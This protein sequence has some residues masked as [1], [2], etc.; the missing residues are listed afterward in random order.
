MFFKK[1][2]FL[3]LSSFRWLNQ[4]KNKDFSKIS[5]KFLKK[6]MLWTGAILLA[7]FAFVSFEIYFPLNP[8]SHE[9]ITYTVQKGWSDTQIANDLQK[10]RIIRSSFFFK[11]YLITS[12]QHSSL[13]AGKYNLSSRMSAYQIAKAM[14]HG[15][16]ISETLVIPEGWD[17]EDIG[18]Y[19][20]SKQI[21]KQDDFVKA[22]SK[23]YS[24]EFDFLKD[25]PKDIGLEGFLFPDT[26][27]VSGAEGCDGIVLIMISN[28]DKK[29]TPEIREQIASQKKTIFDI[30]TMASMLEKEVK[31][32]T[33]K[34]I[35]AGI[36]WKRLS[37]G[38]PLQLDCTVNYITGKSDPGVAIKDSKI[39][40]PYNTYKYKGLPKG[41]ISS[42][43]MDSIIAALNPT[44]TAYWFY[45]GDGITVYSK[46]AEEHAINRAKYLD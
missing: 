31:G 43:G 21:C 46:T 26:Y 6:I 41:P 34:K 4:A 16:A 19:L 23:D 27:K 39:D 28:F 22:A 37:V 45:L 25:K 5:P 24:G 14:T 15:D 8:T 3:D 32:L 38:M 12:L 36:L 20:E 30:V 35:V 33:D 13:Q 2:K 44:K 11:F 7:F 9:T 1:K 10:L 17:I 18:K 29:L 42:P 40:S